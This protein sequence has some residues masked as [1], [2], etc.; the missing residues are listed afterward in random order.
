M[1][2]VTPNY[3]SWIHEESE[4]QHE[5]R[6][7]PTIPTVYLTK[8][9]KAFAI[10]VFPA[11][12]RG[13]VAVS[14]WNNAYGSGNNVLDNGKMTNEVEKVAR[15]LGFVCPPKWRPCHV[16]MQLITF[17]TNFVAK[18]TEAFHY[19]QSRQGHKSFSPEKRL[20]I[21]VSQRVCDLCQKFAMLVY[22]QKGVEVYFF[23]DGSRDYRR[24]QRCPARVTERQ[25]LH[26]YRCQIKSLKTTQVELGYTSLTWEDICKLRQGLRSYIREKFSGNILQHKGYIDLRRIEADPSETIDYYLHNGRFW[27]DKHLQRQEPEIFEYLTSIEWKFHKRGPNSQSQQQGGGENEDDVLFRLMAGLT[28][29]HCKL[30]F[31]LAYPQV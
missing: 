27:I 5:Y 22:L 4:E 1:S 9:E 28:D 25:A 17:Y 16:E 14:G 26:C 10:I 20:G 30:G 11:V 29:V 12:L 23:V 24:C 7:Q 13:T 2:T 21:T 8:E 15:E 31:L 6:W 3:G 18:H 19:L